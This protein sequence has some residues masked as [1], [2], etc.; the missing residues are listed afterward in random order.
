MKIV[1]EKQGYRATL[2]I[3]SAALLKNNVVEVIFLRLQV[4]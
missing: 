4:S 3:F 1:L 2:S